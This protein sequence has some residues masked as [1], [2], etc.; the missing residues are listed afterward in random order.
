MRR[1]DIRTVYLV[2][3]DL[4]VRRSTGFALKTSGF[5]VRA[6]PSGDAFLKERPD[7]PGC[8]LLDVR[9][10]GAD[11]P[12]VQRTLR[13]RGLAWPVLVMTGHGDTATAVAA[14][15]NGAVDFLE[16]P[17]SRDHLLAA[18]ADAF[19]RLE[20]LRHE[21][22][23]ARDARVLV[24]ALTPRE[25]DVL[26]G[27]ARGRPNKTIGHE[28]GISPRTVEIHRAHLMAKLDAASLSDALRIA[29]AAGLGL[30]NAPAPSAE[31]RGAADGPGA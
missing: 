29:F 19:A 5:D 7:D 21:G 1:D 24:N 16:K 3:D 17:F 26:D 10:P 2:D 30:P 22:A 13:E 8:V 18:L 12:A 4:A 25:R 9:M 11:G 31:P 27:L 23:E 6:F 28:L 15:K 20:H 14:M